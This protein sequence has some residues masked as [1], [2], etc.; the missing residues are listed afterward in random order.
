M[1]AQINHMALASAN[2]P[3]VG[4]FYE[5]V[6]GLKCSTH[7]PF[8]GV[9]YSDGYA[10]INFNP[11]RDGYF[12]GLDH[13][14]FVVDDAR[15]VLA[16]MKKN[17]PDS[18]IVKRP[19]TRPFA[20]YSG[21]DPDCNIF[22][23]AEKNADQRKNMY[24]QTAADNWN[25]DRYLN[26]FAIRTPNVQR[27]ADFYQDVFE[28][29]PANIKSDNGSV[30]LTDGRITLTLMPWSISVLEGIVIKRPGPDHIGLRVESVEQLK[31]DIAYA[32]GCN[33]YLAPVQLGGAEEADTRK[34]FFEQWATG[35][36]Q[37]ADP[38]GTW[39]DITEG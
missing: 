10:G 6:F 26:K 2:W 18:D 14:G 37:M 9:V 32:V 22:D 12:G 31:K 7:R 17:W 21:N 3:M 5:A 27:C 30:H 13:F 11:K 1:F 34:A 23:L 15:E 39:L 38:D 16:R 29:Q 33:Q 25:Q 36:Y 24:A 8:H 35:D 28:L 4:R 20:A 19:S